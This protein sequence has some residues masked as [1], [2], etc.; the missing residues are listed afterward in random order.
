M[1]EGGYVTMLQMKVHHSK[2]ISTITAAEII[3]V[4]GKLHIPSFTTQME[5]ARQTMTLNNA[6]FVESERF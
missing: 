4:A 6:T 1:S 3:R 5:I 2:V